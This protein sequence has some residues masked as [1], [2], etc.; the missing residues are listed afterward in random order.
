MKL[1]LFAL[2][3]LLFGTGTAIGQV[4]ISGTIIDQDTNE[5]LIGVNIIEKGTSNGTI[6]DIDGSFSVSVQNRESVLE[7]SYLG[8]NSLEIQVDGKTDFQLTMSLN[9]AELDEIVVI[10][11]GTQ[12]KKVVTG[13]ITKVTAKSLEDMPILRIEDALQGRTSGVRITSNSGQPGESSSVRVRGTTAIGSSE[14]LYVVDGVPIGGGIDF[15]NQ[16]DIESI[17]VLKDAASAGIY[18]TRAS[19]G[20][21]LIT[22]KKGKSGQMEVNYNAYY[23]VQSPAKK[24]ALLNARE[25]GILM[26]ESS[27]AAGGNVIFDDPDALGEGTDWQDA[28]FRENAPIVNHNLSITAGGEKST[29]FASFGYFDQEGIVSESNSNY[30]RFTLKLNSTHK[31]NDHITFGNNFS[32]AR[33]KNQ[34]VSTNSE[35]GSPLSRAINLDPITPLIET[36]PEV[37]NTPVFLSNAVVTNEEGQPY[38]ISSLVTSEVLNP[39]AALA[40][41]NG[42]GRSDKVVGNIFTEI[43]LFSDF[44]FRTSAGAD[45][46]FWGGEGFSPVHYLNGSNRLDINSYN[47]SQ[48]RGLKW[49]IEN[50]LSYSKRINEHNITTVVGTVAEKNNGEGQSGTIRNIPVDNIDDASFLFNTPPEDRT[51]GGFEYQDAL[52]SYFGRLNYGYAE[53]YLL[54]FTLRVDG[55]SKFGSNNKWGY[56]PGI[57]AGWILTD[58]A[59]LSDSNF[60]NFLKI[61]GS[62]G[63]NGSDAIGDFRFVS[64]VGGGRNYVFGLEDLLTNGVSPNAIANPDLRWEETSQLNFGF[65]AKILRNLSLTFDVFEKKTTGMLLDVAVP[66][67]VG[68]AGPIGNIADMSK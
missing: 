50:T 6:S 20:V 33:I 35:F 41:Q 48:N 46:A 5:P 63:V 42:S 29:Y 64:T 43:K 8:Y 9:S 25:Y 68:N 13:A 10:G 23:G 24:L 53:K 49:I 65:N 62:W 18:G 17:E 54:S 16:D 26:N 45:L 32:Y 60:L 39:V 56:F 30:K 4:A 36:D 40:V 1:N 14:P 51:F 66:G 7:I 44:K 19:A 22:T 34:G 3:M 21:V 47:R 57:S 58:E 61:R 59:F 31:I 2:L 52:T 12:K 38:G 37:L 11:Y 27:V 67:Y 15:L 55:S 28:V